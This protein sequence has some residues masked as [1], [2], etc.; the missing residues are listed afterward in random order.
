[1]GKRTVR[2]ANPSNC[3]PEHQEAGSQFGKVSQPDAAR[4]AKSATRP[5]SARSAR[6][7]LQHATD[8]LRTLKQ[9]KSIGLAILS[10]KFIELPFLARKHDSMRPARTADHLGSDVCPRGLCGAKARH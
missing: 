5:I 7:S 1:M 4:R 2:F 3:S 10:W 6:A 8:R 9:P